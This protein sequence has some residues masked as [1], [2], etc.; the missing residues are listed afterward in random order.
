MSSSQPWVSTH[1]ARTQQIVAI[2][3]IDDLELCAYQTSWKSISGQFFKRVKKEEGS[4][5]PCEDIVEVD[6]WYKTRQDQPYENDRKPRFGIWWKED[7]ICLKRPKQPLT[8]ESKKLGC[9]S[10]STKCTYHGMKFG[11]ST[12][13]TIQMYNVCVPEVDTEVLPCNLLLYTERERER[14]NK[15][16]W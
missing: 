1:G 7:F 15:W 16:W 6:E 10:I 4:T 2:H 12:F 5:N 9:L 3:K 14:E 11:M 8:Q 13:H